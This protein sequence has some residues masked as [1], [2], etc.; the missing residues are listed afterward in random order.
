LAA[1]LRQGSISR[2]F[3]LPP[4]TAPERVATMRKA[5]MATLK[6]PELLA[7]A[8]KSGIDVKPETGEEIADQV[9]AI[10]KTSPEILSYLRKGAAQPN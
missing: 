3:M 6:D 4:G 10:Y 7:E 2:P 9:A 8:G 5:L 1:F